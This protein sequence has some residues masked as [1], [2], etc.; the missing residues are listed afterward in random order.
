MFSRD[1]FDRGRRLELLWIIGPLVL[2]A[3]IVT[4]I[5]IGARATQGF[6]N[7]ELAEDVRLASIEGEP[8][9]AEVTDFAWDR[10]CIFGPTVTADEVDA[11]L[12]FEWGVIGGDPSGDRR[13]L[14][15]LVRDDDVVTHFFVAPRV[16]SRG[17]G[18]DACLG[19]EDEQTRL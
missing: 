13:N 7:V 10:A 1:D 18:G 12:G 6:P 16:L 17:D 5:G 2:G 14:V 9:L 19:P 15:V 3:L 4:A 8:L 11:A